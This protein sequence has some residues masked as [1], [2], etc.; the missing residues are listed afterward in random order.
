[1]FSLDA[2]AARSCPVKT[3]NAFHPGFVLP[4][5]EEGLREVFH[6][7]VA[8]QAE[9]LAALRGGFGG[10]L[11]DGPEL[12]GE[13]SAVQEDAALAAMADGVDVLIGPCCRGT[14]SGTAADGPTCWYGAATATTRWRSRSTGCA[15]R[16][17]TTPAWCG[18][19]WPIRR[20]GKPS[21]ATGS[22]TPGG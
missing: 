18:R 21:P 8:F 20:A 11:F 5:P 12:T 1:M 15:T 16:A 4:T 10:S 3:H 14:S 2:Y 6:G 13:P 9:V 7:G 22:G 17:T 19:A